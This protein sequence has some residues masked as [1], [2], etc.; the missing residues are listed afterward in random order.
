MDGAL[1]RGRRRF[2]IVRGPDEPALADH[3]GDELLTMT[4]VAARLK[5]GESTAYRMALRGAIPV[6]RFPGSRLVRVSARALE[7]FIDDQVGA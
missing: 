7:R 6:V 2:R 5:V 1:D 3:A 4:E